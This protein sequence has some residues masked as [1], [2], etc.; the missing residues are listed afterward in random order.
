MVSARRVDARGA[1]GGGGRVVGDDAELPSWLERGDP[2]VH[3]QP[4]DPMQAKVL[5]MMS[6][7]FTTFMLW[8]PAGLVLYWVVNNSLSILQQAIITR[9]IA[10]MGLSK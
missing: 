4:T 1:D 2:A 9:Q 5:K 6:I 10:K 8:F 7:I 3:P